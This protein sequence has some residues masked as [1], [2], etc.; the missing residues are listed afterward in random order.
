MITGFATPEG[1]KKFAERGT[2]ISQQNYKNVNN[3]TLSNVG[4]GTYL[5]NPDIETDKLVEDAIKKSI[6][7]GINV[8]DSAINYRAQKA[9]RSVGNAVA[10]LINNNDISREEIFVST[11]NGYVTNDGDIKEDL[12]KYVAEYILDNDAEISPLE[13][14]FINLSEG[15]I[16][17]YTGD[18]NFS[19][20]T[21]EAIKNI[22]EADVW[23][24]GTPIYNSF[25]SSALKNLFEYID[26]K[27]TAGK[28]A[29]LII[30]ASG[31]SGFTDVQTL[32]TQLMSYFNVITNPRSV[33]V[34]ADTVKDAQITSEDVKSRLKQ[35][36]DETLELARK[37]SN[38]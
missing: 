28:T 37:V 16:D 9:E 6:L 32:L 7:G 27:K 17:Y 22:T 29:G 14:K 24:I 31:N 11:K 1:T 30:V 18:G 20:A 38:N 10:Q 12:M 25:F 2:E 3:L 5:G 8:I 35:L 36:V 13:V 4:I 21:K 26:Y 15:G 23:I 33:F 19:D 34:T